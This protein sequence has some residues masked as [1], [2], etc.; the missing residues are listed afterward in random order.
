MEI[1]V[2]FNWVY[3]FIGNMQRYFSHIYDSTDT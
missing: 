2:V 3:E 1:E